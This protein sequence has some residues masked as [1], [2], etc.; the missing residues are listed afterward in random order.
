MSRATEEF[1]GLLHEETASQI[2][3]MINDED[4]EVRLKAIGQAIRFLK[5][6]QITAV[7]GNDALTSLH[8]SLR[9]SVPSQDELEALRHGSHRL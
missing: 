3:R 4:P 5:D 2:K 7:M 8:E 1:L 6:N 9:D